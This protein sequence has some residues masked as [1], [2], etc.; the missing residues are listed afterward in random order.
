MAF[1]MYICILVIYSISQQDLTTYPIILLKYVVQPSTH[2]SFVPAGDCAKRLCTY[3]IVPR[4]YRSY[5]Y[6]VTCMFLRGYKLDS[7]CV[8]GL[9]IV[10]KQM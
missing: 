6:N 9:I 5:I 2:L 7:L 3:C 8:N 10:S 4:K 1:C